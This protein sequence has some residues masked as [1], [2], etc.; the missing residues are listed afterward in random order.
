M[1]LSRLEIFG[2][3]S[4]GQRVK[5]D[6]KNAVSAVIGPNGTGKTNIIDAIRW[7]IGERR[8]KLLR[9]GSL[10]DVIFKGTSTKKAL[11]MAEVTVTF[12]EC[13][14]LLDFDPDTSR[15][16]ITRR[17]FRDGNSEFIMNGRPVRMKDV[18]QT[19]LAVG[20][21]SGVYSIIEQ[22]MMKQIIDEDP[23]SRRM[24]FE[25]AADI[26][27]FK[28][29]RIATEGKLDTT[30]QD[31]ERVEDIKDE[32]KKNVDR[33]RKQASRAKRY[34][35][36]KE[37]KDALERSIAFTE[38]RKF[39]AKL[40]EII[41]NLKILEDNMSLH[42][43][44]KA[45]IYSEESNEKQLE[46]DARESREEVAQELSDSQKTV[47]RLETDI[48][49]WK[50]KIK[51]ADSEIERAHREKT[52]AKEK[53]SEL[54]IEEDELEEQKEKL[55]RELPALRTNE[56]E[57]QI[58]E[59]DLEVQKLRQSRS[60]LYETKEDIERRKWQWQQSNK[61]LTE[62]KENQK[63]NLYHVLSRISEL[64]EKLEEK[65][66]TSVGFAVADLENEIEH[67]RVE[68][69]N[70]T[71][72]RRDIERHLSKTRDAVIEKDGEISRIRGELAGISAHSDDIRDALIKRKDQFGI[73]GTLADHLIPENDDAAKMLQVALGRKA[74]YFIVE[75]PEEAESAIEFLIERKLGLSGFIVLSELSTDGAEGQLLKMVSAEDRRLL[76]LI[77]NIDTVTKPEDRDSSL[78]YMPAE[79]PENAACTISMFLQTG[80][81]YGGYTE[82]GI[83]NIKARERKLT[84]LL[85]ETEASVSELSK[86]ANDLEAQLALNR[87]KND[88]AA[89]ELKIKEK[90]LTNT[91]LEKKQLDL[92]IGNIERE[93][94]AKRAESMEIN[95]QLK[96]IEVKLTEKP[97]DFDK[98]DEI[99]RNIRVLSSK[100]TDLTDTRR[101]LER[102]Q[103]DI[104]FELL[105]KTDQIKRTIDQISRIGI[106]I[107]EMRR[108]LE[109]ARKT[110]IEA[111]AQKSTGNVLIAEM[112]EELEVQFAKSEKLKSVLEDL[113][114]KE[115]EIR[116]KLNSLSLRSRELETVITDLEERYH[117]LD[118]EKIRLEE[119]I[120]TL[121]NDYPSISSYEIEPIADTQIE[122]A[123]E[124]LGALKER[125]EAFGAVNFEAEEQYELENSRYEHYNNQ[126]KDINQSVKTLR[127]SITKLNS[128][129]ERM[130][131]ETFEETRR[132]FKILFRELF[133]GG[134]ADIELVNKDGTKEDINVLEANINVITQPAG[135]RRLSITQLSQGEKSLVAIA[136]L[137]GL[138]LV[139][140]SPFCFLDEVDAPLDETNVARFIKIVRR[141]QENTQ[142]ILIT[143]NRKTMQAMDNL[144][145]MTM[146]QGISQVVGLAF[147]EINRQY[148]DEIGA[149]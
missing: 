48:A 25:E 20:I 140:P 18:R 23:D 94:S 98:Q 88:K 130:F 133:N 13:L 115:K 144:Y 11:N 138:Y 99:E 100:I 85:K 54:S 87:E 108:T 14:G 53:I 5:V 4:F 66:K 105:K 89:I 76:S 83:I 31:M 126:L 39:S 96:E 107:S 62:R 3:K 142:F 55:N 27:K 74:D 57:K 80:L 121:L 30:L 123:R 127:Q 50:E 113:R 33:L 7:V 146:E 75:K 73:K 9:G 122:S 70:L 84:R 147:E 36:L 67:N 6:F 112:E 46:K 125:I 132:N 77:K 28:S 64:E 12:E 16:T 69:E 148:L 58:S 61:Q 136:L 93:I 92:D 102:K 63:D 10:D 106:S 119:K 95:N 110:E 128:E 129:A 2:F 81:R 118:N 79:L 143:H 149:K 141:F 109:N 114:E 139:R 78:P 42:R 135:K 116:K 24:L 26:L 17:A 47:S 68:L 137:F 145:G 8:I 15:L 90:K 45:E 32:I 103:K 21:S 86:T 59:V 60:K 134:D 71:S 44:E 56:I 82:R 1:Y 37:E 117:K 43:K 65:E 97:P 38:H 111:A 91:L 72:A 52:I 131:K 22:H 101:E 35:N 124:N 41:G 51:Q 49:V 120:S 34:S 19:L 29:D 40:E 104:S